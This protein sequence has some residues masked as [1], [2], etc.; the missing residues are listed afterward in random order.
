MQGKYEKSKPLIIGQMIIYA[1]VLIIFL[2]YFIPV[3]LE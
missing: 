3:G 2:Y 1:A